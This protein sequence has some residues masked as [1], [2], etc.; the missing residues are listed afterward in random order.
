MIR[1]TI[2]E[3]FL[4][5]REKFGERVLVHRHW[6]H[7]HPE[8]AFAEKETTNYIM[9]QLE[10]VGIPY[11]RIGTCGLYADL[12]ADSAYPTIAIR[13]EIDGLPV[14]EETGLPFASI[15]DGKMH[16]C[17][18]DANT[19]IVLTLAE[20]LAEEKQN[21]KCNVRF[22]FE[23]AEEIGEGAN[24]MIQHGAL[25]NPKPEEILLFHF[26]NETRDTVEINRK[27]STA[28]IAGLQIAIK[29]RA[30]HFSQYDEGIDAMYAASKL[31]TAARE[32]NER[33][34]VEYPFILGFGLMQAGSSGNIVAERAE[35]KGSLRTFTKKDFEILYG[36][37]IQKVREIELE[38]GA[39][40]QVEITKIIPPIINDDNMVEHACEIGQYLGR[41]HFQ[42]V[43]EPFL[44]GDNAA[45]Y[46]EEIPGLHVVFMAKKEGEAT[47]PIHNS[48]FDL[49]EK[50][51]IK[52]LEFLLAFVVSSF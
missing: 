28:Q 32:I 5:H 18:H 45:Y 44:A 10:H 43:D 50:E 24:Y 3:Q 33:V 34:T 49:D 47:Y 7:Q 2:V 46:L 6:L 13:A 17:G 30:S 51:I 25:E 42:V 14:K 38:T 19:A 52:A 26:G 12:L 39:D 29:G 27:I 21:L 11:K 35:L 23:P 41:K 20:V 36:E 1:K 22:I 9:K 31:I 48:R 8:L 15:Y 4:S 37:F 16:A 40:I